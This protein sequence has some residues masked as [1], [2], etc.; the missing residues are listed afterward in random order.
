MTKKIDRYLMK[1]LCNSDEDFYVKLESKI[2]NK[3]YLVKALRCISR[4][5]FK[6]EGI[7]TWVKIEDTIRVDKQGDIIYS[8][9]KFRD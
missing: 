6:L 1:I 3:V 4:M 9:I 2:N 8:E 7:N 5:E